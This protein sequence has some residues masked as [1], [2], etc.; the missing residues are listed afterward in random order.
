MQLPFV[1][2]VFALLLIAI[3]CT[4]ELETGPRAVAL[5]F[6]WSALVVG[7]LYVARARGRRVEDLLVPGPGAARRALGVCLRLGILPYAAAAWVA[8]VAT[9]VLTR[10]ASFDVVTPGLLLGALP[11]PWERG[12]I[13][14]AGAGRILNLCFEFPPVLAAARYRPLLDGV[15][16]C[17]EHLREAAEWVAER[18]R[19]GE[20]VL[21]HCAQGHG[22]S[23]CV[24]AAALVALGEAATV[25]AAIARVVAARPGVQLGAAHRAALE[26]FARAVPGSSR[27]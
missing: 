16:P 6:G 5:G 3:G 9:R 22:R 17:A 1:L 21:V 23:A 13:R 7:A 24:V 11:L 18:R 4:P 19:A 27:G 14:R 26:A 15:A 12:R 20:V 2:P 8:L 25:E 10:E